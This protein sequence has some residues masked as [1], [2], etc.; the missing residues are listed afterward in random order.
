MTNLHLDEVFDLKKEKL[1]VLVYFLSQELTKFTPYAYQLIPKKNILVT[2]IKEN[3]KVENPYSFFS[4]SDSQKEDFCNAI[5][6]CGLLGDYAV[7]LKDFTLI[8]KKLV[9]RKFTGK[10][11][12]SN[13]PVLD[14]FYKAAAQN[15]L[16]SEELYKNYHFVS[17][18]EESLTRLEEI[19]S[20]S[21]NTALT[22]MLKIV[23]DDFAIT[24]ADDLQNLIDKM[25]IGYNKVDLAKIPKGKITEQLITIYTKFYKLRLEDL[26]H[27]VN[28]IRIELKVNEGNLADAEEIL[29]D[30]V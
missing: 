28:L 7:E 20:V 24:L 26:R 8:D 27:L 10:L 22:K 21:I 1:S 5:I 17:L 23:H 29:A 3:H 12:D 16:L 25:T 19:I 15:H 9:K 4:L 30:G 11:E 14:I 18:I 2:K 6:I 13:R